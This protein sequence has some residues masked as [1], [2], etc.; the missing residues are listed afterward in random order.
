MIRTH[1]AGTLRASDA[2]TTVTLAGWVAR[3]RDHGGVIFVD[4]RDAS[5]VVQVVFR[6]EDAHALRNEY[7]VLVTGEVTRR[8]EGN[9]NPD[10]ATGD[11]EV[12]ASDLTVLSNNLETERPAEAC[13]RHKASLRKL[14]S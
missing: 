11:V 10:L 4:L 9:E 2:G 14:A 12:V 8:P 7:C 13:E 5:G 1:N 3:R 6:E